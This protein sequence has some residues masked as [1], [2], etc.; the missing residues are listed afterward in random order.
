MVTKAARA[1]LKGRLEVRTIRPTP[2]GSTNEM[3]P[4]GMYGY[5]LY[6]TTP[7]APNHWCVFWPELKGKIPGTILHYNDSFRACLVKKEDLEI[8]GNRGYVER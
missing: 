1:Y 5:V 8:T 7:H 2:M 4:E 6:G 3:L